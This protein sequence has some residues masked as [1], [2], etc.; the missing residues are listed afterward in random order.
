MSKASQSALQRYQARREGRLAASPSRTRRRTVRPGVLLAVAILLLASAA[1]GGW[2]V[3]RE[4]A[5]L[6]LDYEID[7]SDAPRGSLDL[8][9]VLTGDLPRHLDLV[10]PPGFFGDPDSG[11][12]ANTPTAQAVDG[13]GR[14]GRSLAVARTDDGWRVST[15]GVDQVA[16]G[17]R[18]D[19]S[20]PDHLEH[21]IRRFISNPVNGGVRVA[22]FEIFLVPLGRPVGDIT[23]S[24]RNPDDLPVLT[25]WP[26][27]V[28]EPART[29]AIP[30]SAGLAHL[31]DGRSYL[32]VEARGRRATAPRPTPPESPEASRVFHPRDLADLNNALL[33]CGNLRTASTKARDCDIRFA[34]D[35]RWLFADDEALDLV[36]RV[37]RTEVGFFGSAPSPRITVLLAANE[38]ST[39]ERFDTYGAHTG[40]SVLVMIDARTTWGELE[41]QAA[42]VIAHEMFHG[43]LGEAIPQE[44]PAML[45]FT[46]GATTW[47][48]ARMLTAAGVWSPDHARR[49]LQRRLERDYEQNRLLG[50]RAV[51]DVA[52]D[53]MSDD[54]EAVRFAY[55]GGVAVCVALD[56]WLARH[57]G[58]E[59]P[60]DGV[61]RHLYNTRD[62]RPLTRASLETAVYEVT[63]VDC[64][65][66]LDSHVYGK[67]ALPL[68]EDLI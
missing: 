39:P 12:D 66:W 50:E 55:A 33:V 18:V 63:G 7:L 54:A 68:P 45:W 43:W 59:R 56:S 28:R 32:P 20:P 10:F 27:L 38:V 53:V 29:P 42:S 47:Y 57:G 62:G 31:G 19:L 6:N 34:T 35:R 61:L 17:Y 13:Q 23:V 8:H 48:A 21:D 58:L 22:G 40:S 26:P 51:A 30:D 15:D 1:A 41:D 36:R 37:A 65:P 64:A 25:P 2:Y 52:A 67:T 24:L 4:P 49:V 60:L 16:F 14:R 5:P 46:E 44:D 3:L 9:L 11:V